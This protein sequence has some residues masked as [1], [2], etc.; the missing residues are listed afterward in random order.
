MRNALAM[1]APGLAR[2]AARPSGRPARSARCAGAR[3]DATGDRPK[4]G[5]APQPEPQRW[6]FMAWLDGILHPQGAALATYGIGQSWSGSVAACALLTA[7]CQI[8]CA[9]WWRVAFFVCC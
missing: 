4:A 8:C 7:H 2:L 3:A 9:A 5:T 1:P 6:N